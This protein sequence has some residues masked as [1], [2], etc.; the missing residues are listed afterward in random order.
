MIVFNLSCSE[1]H[2]FDGWFRSSADFDSQLRMG[3]VECPVCGDANITKQLSAPRINVGAA[4]TANPAAVAD[5]NAIPGLT[6]TQP[7]PA[8]T[9]IPGLQQHMLAQFKKYVVTHTENVGN[10]FA[11]TARRMHYGEEEHRGIRGHVS[12]DDAQALH[13][14]GIDTMSLPPGVLLDES[15]Q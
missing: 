4:A 15:L 13:D 7:V 10:R 11:E 6:G 1:N 2:S 3:L 14:E 9:M 5:N 8:A 12:P